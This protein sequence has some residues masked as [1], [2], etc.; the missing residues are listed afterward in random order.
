MTDDQKDLV[1]VTDPTE[2]GHMQMLDELVVNVSEFGKNT[3][4]RDLFLEDGD[5][6]SHRP[7]LCI[8]CKKEFYNKRK[9]RK[10]GR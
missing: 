4:T 10:T 7:M 1:S 5:G 9:D 2:I 3:T 8:T 6:G